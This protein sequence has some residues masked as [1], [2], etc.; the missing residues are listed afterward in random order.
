MTNTGFQSLLALLATCAL[1][2]QAFAAEPLGRL[3][4]VDGNGAV[5]GWAADPDTPA[6]AVT[7][8][9]YLD[10]PAG[11][12]TFAGSVAA[13][14]ASA[15]S[16]VTGNHGFRYSVP[17][18]IPGR[19]VYAYA[20]DTSGQAPNPQIAGSG[21]LI[22]A[23]G[24][25]PSVPAPAATNGTP[26]GRLTSVANGVA[27]GW[28]GDPDT[29]FQAVSV[30]FY[31]DYPAG[32]GTFAGAVSAS[33]ASPSA[34]LAGNHGFSYAVPNAIPG[35]KVYAYA[36]DTSGQPPNPQITGSGMLVGGA[37]TPGVTA[38]TPPGPPALDVA[39]EIFSPSGQ[40]EA[41][42]HGGGNIY[43]PSVL[44]FNGQYMMWYGGFGKDGHDRIHLSTSADGLSNWLKRGVVLENRNS[45][46][47]TV[48]HVNDPSVILVN[49]VLHMYYTEA[50]QGFNDTVAL[51]TSSDGF[52][53]QL[54]G[55]VLR[56]TPRTP[57][58]PVWDDRLVG[59]PSILYVNGTYYLA[60]DGTTYNNVVVSP[61][62]NP[63]F[64]RHVGMAT[65]TDGR[66]FTKLMD[67]NEPRKILDNSG[68]VDLALVNGTYVLFS[69]SRTGVQFAVG[70]SPTAPFTRRGQLLGTS[71][72]AFDLHGHITPAWL[73]T[74]GGSARIYLGGARRSDWTG[75]TMGVVELSGGTVNRLR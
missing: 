12:G 47:G 31:L 43:A 74:P 40:T 72:S 67:G 53:W 15:S 13:D 26:R 58:T 65:S 18:G 42:I 39:R 14:Q 28:A 33:M 1:A 2:T 64:S 22:T 70:S 51:A 62:T 23:G 56:P 34:T 54:Q 7:V 52:N 68:A 8:H 46:G 5:S 30:H 24:S 32:R 20:L 49:G 75:Q 17:N 38:P 6:Q 55:H 29:P 37:S 3:E 9:F 57:G 44:Y 21:I 27:T 4:S 59:R 50:G 10:Y 69:E 41:S 45:G 16:S 35:R 11:Q 61:P 71:G 63:T 60:F 36:L 48:N 19:R 25:T 73:V 66:N